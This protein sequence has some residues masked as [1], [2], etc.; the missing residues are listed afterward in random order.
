LLCHIEIEAF[1]ALRRGIGEIVRSL[2]RSAH[3]MRVIGWKLEEFL[4]AE[5][6]VFPIS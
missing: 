5:F 1:V 2:R 6:P 4:A 3:S